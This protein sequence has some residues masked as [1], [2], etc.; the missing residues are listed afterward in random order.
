MRARGLDDRIVAAYKA[1][2]I[3]DGRLATLALVFALILSNLRLA[4][5]WVRTRPPELEAAL[6]S[7]VLIGIFLAWRNL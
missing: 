2:R 7:G 3:G 1:G 6:W 5:R 4:V